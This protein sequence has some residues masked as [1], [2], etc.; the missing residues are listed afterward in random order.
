ME[1]SARIYKELLKENEELKAQ[2]ETTQQNQ[3]QYQTQEATTPT[4]Y[5]SPYAQELESLAGELRNSNF[6]YT[7]EEDPSWQAARKEYLLGAERTA[8]DVLAK[9]SVNTGGRASS[10]A[11]TAAAQAAN[12]MRASF[13]QEEAE[14]YDAAY[15]RY[16]QE[17][18]KK[19]Q[20]YDNLLT[21]DAT[22]YDRW[23][24]EKTLAQEQKDKAYDDLVTL[25][26]HTGHT[27]SA[28][29][30]A[31]ADMSA[32]EAASWK[33]Y[34]QTQ[35]ALAQSSGSSSGG[36][37]GS[38]GSSGTGGG[39]S[40]VG[41]SLA[42]DIAAIQ[43][44]E[45]YDAAMQAID[46]AYANGVIVG[47]ESKSE[48]KSQVTS[49]ETGVDTSGWSL[50]AQNTYN[51]MVR[52]RKNGKSDVYILNYLKRVLDA[53]NLTSNEVKQITKALGIG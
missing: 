29:E 52:A 48:Y 37:S 51:N 26:M 19:L 39:S 35:L 22:N 40:N 46:D 1:T 23:L 6:R 21:Q 47:V 50:F 42:D 3:T 41:S 53:G 13:S 49:A 27:P 38:S 12:D 36:S 5:V 15:S 32:S 45:G 8:E 43:K 4:E 14:I 30:L 34:Y 7:K 31:A 25:I 9:A 44:A 10:Y 33:N 2:L 28:E 16:Y 24:T 17:Y 11:V 18:S 20:D